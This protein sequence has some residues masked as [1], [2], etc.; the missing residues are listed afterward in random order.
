MKYCKKC[1][2]LYSSLLEVCPKCNAV[3]TSPP[4][5]EEPAEPTQKERR[6]RW[7]AIGLGVPALVCF[8]Y[9]VYSI[10]AKLGAF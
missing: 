2:V 6:R 7:L 4:P 1:G 3:L 9:F 10:F 8:L 5:Q